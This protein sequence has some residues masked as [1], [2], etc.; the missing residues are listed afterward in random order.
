M[1]AFSDRVEFQWRTPGDDPNGIGI[2]AYNVYRDGNFLFTDSAETRV[3]DTTVS[4]G[5]TYSY[6]IDAVDFHANVSSTTV[7]VATPSAW[8]IDPRRVGTRPTGAYWGGG[9]EQLD[10]R[11]GNLNFTVPLVTAATRNGGGAKFSLSY[12]SQMW[13]RDANGTWMLGRDV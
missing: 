2:Y 4:P 13:R 9:G 5:V 6:R 12:N 1:S 10:V 8:T 11:S 3:D 7:S